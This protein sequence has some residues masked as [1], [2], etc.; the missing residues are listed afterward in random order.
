MWR[1]S[2]HKEKASTILLLSESEVST[3]LK[4]LQKLTVVI[5]D[6][7]V[8]IEAIKIPLLDANTSYRRA[9]DL[10]KNLFRHYFELS[11]KVRRDPL[12]RMHYTEM[13]IIVGSSSNN[14]GD[15][16]VATKRTFCKCCEECHVI[17]IVL[18]LRIAVWI[19]PTP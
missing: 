13:S 10:H 14:A 19:M 7:L 3:C 5:S 2:V 1:T 8:V 18:T 16:L 17:L 15:G 12:V 9:V 11:G 4:S 6:L